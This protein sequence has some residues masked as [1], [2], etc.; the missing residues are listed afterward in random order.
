MEEKNNIAMYYQTATCGNE[1]FILIRIINKS[2]HNAAVEWSLEKGSL[3][4][5]FAILAQTNRIGT[6]PSNENHAAINDLAESIP[7]GK[8]I[9]TLH[10]NFNIH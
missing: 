9:Y 5:K 7:E 4:N 8:T 2:K 10:P 1:P 6:C 3:K